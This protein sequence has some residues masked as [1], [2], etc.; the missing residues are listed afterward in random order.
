[1]TDTII[2]LE[3]VNPIEYFGVNN[4]KLDI[5]KK[6]FPLLKILSRGTQIKLSG[7]PEQIEE[8]KEKIDLLIQYLQRNGHMS[9]NYFEQILGGDDEKVVDNFLDRNPNDVLVFGP[10]G[11]TVR[12]RTQN[13]KL[14]VQACDKNDILFAIGPAGTGKTYTAVALA[15][16]PI[17]LLHWQ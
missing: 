10:N 16:K 1:L 3:T 17:L 13:Q 6:K 15:V 2:N 11:K 7:A 14:M 8:A 4:G 5:L 9:E 12:A